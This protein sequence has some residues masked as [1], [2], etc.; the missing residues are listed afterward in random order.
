MFHFNL[1]KFFFP[2]EEAFVQ[3]FASVEP[4][5]CI[6]VKFY[7]RIIAYV[8]NIQEEIIYSVAHFTI[9]FQPVTKRLLKC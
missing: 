7:F 3:L 8:I 2:N 9:Q 1:K 5:H 6:Y 4:Q